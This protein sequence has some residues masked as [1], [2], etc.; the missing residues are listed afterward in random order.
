MVDNSGRLIEQ[1]GQARQMIRAYFEAP[2]CEWERRFHDDQ[3]ACLQ[4]GDTHVCEWLYQ[5]DPAPDFSTY[6][7]EQLRSALQF[8][9]GYLDGRM[10][11]AGH[12]PMRCHCAS[13]QW[14][15]DAYGL[16]QRT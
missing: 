3:Q 14:V 6:S 11:E 2:D 1:L 7:D 8:A 9:V 16:L 13:C 15:R 5:Q 10:I 4:C 12:T